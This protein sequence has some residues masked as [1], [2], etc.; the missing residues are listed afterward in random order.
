MINLTNND[1]RKIQAWLKANAIKDSELEAA[2]S[3]SDSDS[4]AIVQN[5]Q[6]KKLSFRTIKDFIAAGC[7]SKKTL[8]E[9]NALPVKEKNHLYLI[10]DTNQ[11]IVEGKPYGFS[12]EDAK[13][14]DTLFSWYESVTEEDADDIINKWQE[15]VNFLDGISDERKL[16]AIIDVFDKEVSNIKEG[17]TI[18]GKAK[19]DA[20]GN[21]IHDY[22]IAKKDMPDLS[23]YKNK[24]S[25]GD[26]LFLNISSNIL[27][28]NIKENIIGAALI[29]KEESSAIGTYLTSKKQEDGSIPVIIFTDT[30]IVSIV[31][32]PETNS[33]N[34][35]DNLEWPVKADTFLSGIINLTS[36]TSIKQKQKLLKNT[37]EV[38]YCVIG[39]SNGVIPSTQKAVNVPVNAVKLLQYS[40]P[41]NAITNIINIAI[42]LAS[43]QIPTVGVN[44]GDI[45]GLTRTKVKIKHLEAILGID[46][47]GVSGDAEIEL[48]QYKILST[49]DA[50]GT[51]YNGIPS[52][53]PGLMSPGDKDLVSK[54]PKIENDV[55]NALPRAE[56]F[57][58]LWNDNM[59]NCLDTGVYP[60]CT[61]GRPEG[62][63]GTYTCI[64]TRTSTDDGNY[65]TIEQT[66]YG[67]QDELGKIYKRI[68]FYKKDG[69]DTQYGKWISISDFPYV[70]ELENQMQPITQAEYDTLVAEGKVENRLYFIVED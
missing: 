40:S 42:N 27:E 64:V 38:I 46:I 69:T 10:T 2:V 14:L 37:D 56:R 25:S 52:G 34:I 55:S 13:K 41:D 35:V 12:A 51:N 8:A 16:T 70:Q 49:N 9:Y 50:K 36:E 68:I 43:I 31:Y 62:S 67:R 29:A 45:I 21:I 3:V 7:I 61:L 28:G 63:K 57:P 59:N 54:I 19:M 15:I 60:W 22:Y 24:L 66:A 6:S 53:V 1:Y 30:L 44:V 65:H 33:Y 5:G 23:G 58:S 32:F 47:P 4:M 17:K 39:D 20:L 48:Y 18:A 11:I 26:Y